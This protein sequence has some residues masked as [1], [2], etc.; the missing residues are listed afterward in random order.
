ME[1]QQE[2]K[3]LQEFFRSID[4]RKNE[5]IQARSVFDQGRYVSS[6]GYGQTSKVAGL[7]YIYI[8]IYPSLL[9]YYAR[10]FAPFFA[11]L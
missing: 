4:D 1:R 7:I 2:K 10:I 5:L 6:V 11:H 3:E 9:P 8:Y